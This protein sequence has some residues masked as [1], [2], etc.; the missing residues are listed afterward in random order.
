[1][2]LTVDAVGN[3]PMGDKVRAQLGGFCSHPGGRCRCLDLGHNRGTGEKWSDFEY[4]VKVE[5]EVFD[6]FVGVEERGIKNDSQGFRTEQLE[7]WSCHSLQW[8]TLKE[9]QN[10]GAIHQEPCLGLVR[11]EMPINTSKWRY[12]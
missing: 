6:V 5:S 1:M 11:C 7:G 9:V 8:G 3:R 2:G 4:I 12:Q 10:S